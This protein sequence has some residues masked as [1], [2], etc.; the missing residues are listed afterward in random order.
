MLRR[1]AQPEEQLVSWNGSQEA[2]LRPSDLAAGVI[3]WLWRNGLRDE[4]VSIL[5]QIWR[6]VRCRQ[7]GNPEP[8]IPW[9]ADSALDGFR[10]AA[11]R[12][13]DDED[14]TEFAGL[15]RERFVVQEVERAIEDLSSR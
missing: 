9:P 14:Q 12:D 7:E 3:V 8:C 10:I 11:Y 15:F 1:G 4:A 6:T 5:V 2:P 13:W